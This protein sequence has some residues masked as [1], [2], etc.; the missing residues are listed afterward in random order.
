MRNF[1]LLLVLSLP[2]TAY[3]QEMRFRMEEECTTQGGSLVFKC[4]KEQT[5]FTIIKNGKRFT[6]VN[7]ATGTTYE[8]KVL[9]SDNH[10]TVLQNPVGFNGTS[11]IHLTSADNRFYWVE[12]AYSTILK[13]REMTVRSGRRIK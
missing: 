1:F 12:V 5:E 2:L 3:S 8:L 7:S 13:N 6:G 10:I 4:I 11:T 9:E